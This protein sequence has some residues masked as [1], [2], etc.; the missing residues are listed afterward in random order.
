MP[1]VKYAALFPNVKTASADARM[2]ESGLSPERAST[3]SVRSCRSRNI[4]V[5]VN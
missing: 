5:N 1:L 3:V 2:R 4:G